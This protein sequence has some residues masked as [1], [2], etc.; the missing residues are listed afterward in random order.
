MNN[1][2][3]FAER[4]KKS[5]HLILVVDDEPI[6]LQ[7]MQNIIK[8]FGYKTV[9]A[10]NG[11]EGVAMAMKMKPDL[12]MLDINMPVMDGIEAC[13]KLKE[14]ETLADIPVIF[15]TGGADNI[16]L[17]RAFDA[18]CVDYVSKSAKV[19][20]IRARIKAAFSQLRLQQ[21][22]I[23]NERLSGVL[24]MAGAICHELGQPLQ[25]LYLYFDALDEKTLARNG[26]GKNI[27]AI[28]RNV[29]R[30]SSIIKK[31]SF[32]RKYESR[33]YLKGTKIIDIDKASEL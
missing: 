18:G 14:D 23:E 25:S 29:Q 4:E 26:L 27:E 2:E 10:T 11:E 17:K 30:M 3:R 28:K 21:K 31:V 33:D 13:Q 22:L 20:E 8:K 5:A 1:I 16:T 9:T 19:A 7:V 32:I 15:V 6:I 24:E 12:I